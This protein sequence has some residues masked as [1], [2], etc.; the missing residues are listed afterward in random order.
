M[1]RLVY[2]LLIKPL[3]I[4]PFWILYRVSDVL[5]FIVYYLLRYRKDVVRQNIAN[6]FPEMTEK[7]RTKIVKSSYAQFCD[8]II[9]SVKNFSI[10][11]DES[12]RRAKVVNFEVAD[13]Y[14]DQGKSII[15]VLGH[16]AN[17]ENM[18][19]GGGSYLKHD[20]TVLFHPL[21][22]E[23]FNKK[24]HESRSQFGTKMVSKDEVAKFLTG[25]PDK[26]IALVFV[27]DQSPKMKSN[28]K[29]YWTKFMNRDV[30]VAYGPEL[31]A[32]KY[33]MPVIFAEVNRV[34]RGYYEAH[35]MVLEEEPRTT[36]DYDISERHVRTLERQIRNDP[37]HYLW[38]HR[39][40]KHKKPEQD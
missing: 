36:P 27:A 37:R 26:P 12:K 5:Y 40:W 1:A 16:N 35:L 23:F 14:F 31:Y 2:Y 39:R 17:W 10:S 38:T 13:Q 7:E 11:E 34:K 6:A 32:K 21:K 33:N 24:V 8:L 20:L 9:E 22:N 3:S 19:V 25:Q 4:L 30:P 18:A 15:L 28:K 29:V